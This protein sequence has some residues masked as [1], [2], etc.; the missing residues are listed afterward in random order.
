MNAFAYLCMF[1]FKSKINSSILTDFF[2]FM[3]KISS[4]KLFETWNFKLR[5]T[6]ENDFLF[7]FGKHYRKIILRVVCFKIFPKNLFLITL[8]KNVFLFRGLNILVNHVKSH[9]KWF[10]SPLLK[11]W[12]SL[13][14]FDVSLL[15][16]NFW[17]YL[18]I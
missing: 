14:G 18:D 9:V 16:F 6:T 11:N 15:F 12:K 3:N 5:L 7:V 17:W 10:Q 2:N 4:F 1:A 13:C 8:R